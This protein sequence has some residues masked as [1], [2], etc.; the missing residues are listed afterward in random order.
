MRVVGVSRP[1]TR[2][3]SRGPGATSAPG[4]AARSCLRSLFGRGAALDADR[5][6]HGR[7]DRPFSAHTVALDPEEERPVERGAR[8]KGDPGAERE[9]DLVE[10][11]EQLGVVVAHADD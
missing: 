1:G 11:A 4:P 5:G 7:T 10:V 9:A 3:V 8:D 2:G 6:G